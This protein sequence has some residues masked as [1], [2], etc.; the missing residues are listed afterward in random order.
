MLALLYV[1]LMYLIST[2][3]HCIFTY[4]S[5]PAGGECLIKKYVYVRALYISKFAWGALPLSFF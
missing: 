1:L 5:V 2:Q 3:R 4:A